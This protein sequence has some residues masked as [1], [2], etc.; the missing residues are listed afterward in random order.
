[1]AGQPEKDIWGLPMSSPAEQ[2]IVLDFNKTNSCPLT[3]T[4]LH[5]MVEAQAERTPNKPAVACGTVEFTYSQLMGYVNRLA[6]VLQVAGV[7]EGSIVGLLLNRT[8]DIC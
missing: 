1:M 5:D 4:C 7:V 6:A 2:G 8:E 3:E